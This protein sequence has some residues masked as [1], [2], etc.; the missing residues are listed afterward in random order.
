MRVGDNFMYQNY[1]STLSNLKSQMDQATEEVSS[2]K[3][4]VVPSDDPSAYAQNLEVLSQLSQNTQYKSNLTSLQTL[5]GYYQNSLNTVSS[6]LTSAKQLAVQMASSTVDASSRTAAASQV[7]DM[8]S[9]LVAVGNTKVGD[10]YIFGG[11]KADTAPYAA[12]GTFSGTSSVGQVAVDSST[13]MA[14]GISGNTVF[15]GTVNGQDVNIFTT[16]QQFATDLTNNDTS[17][18]QTDTTNLDNC[19]S[20][21]ANNLSYV[22]TYADDISSLLT[23]NSNTDTTL[24]QTSSSL[25]GVDMA[26]AVSD[27]TTL[28][29]AY[30]AALYTM[31]KVESLS[32]LNY[33]PYA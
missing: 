1:V 31:S 14:A 20:L 21:T 4:V 5:S 10:T 13:T 7:D 12:D 29:T 25:T 26:Q 2:G 24:N 27:Y 23:T 11:T 33:L 9:Q 15:D 6:V 19:V 22:G 3:K 17:A 16:L 32:I 18:L 28:S 8:I 30:Q